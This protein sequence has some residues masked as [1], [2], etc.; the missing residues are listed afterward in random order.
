MARIGW[1]DAV[2]CGVRYGGPN[3]L[4][5]GNIYICGGCMVGR[6]VSGDGL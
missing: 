2:G 1:R 5:V 3:D 6:V 4:P